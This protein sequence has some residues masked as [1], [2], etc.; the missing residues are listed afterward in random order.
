MNLKTSSVFIKGL[1]SVYYVL[2]LYWKQWPVRLFGVTGGIWGRDSFWERIINIWK[3]GL[4]EKDARVNSGKMNMMKCAIFS[5]EFKFGWEGGG[6][7]FKEAPK[8]QGGT[9]LTNLV[10]FVIGQTESTI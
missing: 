9:K 10:I 3:G 4:R 8:I 5:G 7:N 6:E 1:C 2:F